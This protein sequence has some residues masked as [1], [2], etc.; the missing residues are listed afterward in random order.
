MAR[1]RNEQ[2]YEQQR[3]FILETGLK[4]LQSSSYKA[5]GVNDVIAESGIPKGSFYH[6]FKSKEAFGLAVA[7]HYHA[8]QMCMAHRLL[9]DTT[10]APKQRLKD[11]FEEARLEFVAR[12]FS[13]GCLM[14]NL[15]TELGQSNPNFQSLL[16]QQ[17]TELATEIAQCIDE[18]GT[19]AIGVSEL[20]SQEAADWL[21]NNWSGALSRMKI[22]VSDAP[23]KLFEKTLFKD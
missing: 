15:S 5:V 4:L 6:Y 1:I 14:C 17:W 11:F 9:G 20:S 19:A 16:A 8:K 22:T 13:D 21:L 3:T 10:K 23:L 18:I 2:Q 7:E 12:D